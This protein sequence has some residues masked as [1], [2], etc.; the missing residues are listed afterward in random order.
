M[1]VFAGE[2]ETISLLP[3]LVIVAAGILF[4]ALK[5]FLTL[6]GYTV[7][8]DRER[9]TLSH[10]LLNRQS[11]TF[12]LKK[13]NAVVVHQSLL[14]RLCKRAYVEV[15]VIGYGDAKARPRL[16]LYAPLAEVERIRDALTGDFGDFEAPQKLARAGFWQKQLVLLLWAL[17]AFGLIGSFSPLWGAAAAVFLLL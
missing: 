8:A 17:A 11:Y 3:L 7:S 5:Q 16:C 12:E 10:G 15:V 6:Y 4:A 13:I 2:A 1:P 9:V 14:A